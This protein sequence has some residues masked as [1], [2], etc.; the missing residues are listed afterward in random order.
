MVSEASSWALQV[1]AAVSN[2]TDPCRQEILNCSGL[3][4]M[5]DMVVHRSPP[6]TNKRHCVCCMYN[7]ALGSELV[8]DLFANDRPFTEALLEHLADSTMRST[9]AILLAL[10]SAG[11][12]DRKD[13]LSDAGAIETISDTLVNL[14][15]AE[16]ITKAPLASC[17]RKLLE[18]DDERARKLQQNSL[19]VSKLSLIGYASIH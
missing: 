13:A 14:P 3:V 12:E 17:L 19:T 18:D 16:L 1:L 9:S 11:S 15:D 4:V 10:M 5:M 6:D 7:L 8:K 2:P